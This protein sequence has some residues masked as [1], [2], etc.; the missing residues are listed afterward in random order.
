VAILVMGTGR[1]ARRVRVRV[2]VAMMK[3][4]LVDAVDGGCWFNSKYHGDAGMLERFRAL[5]G[6]VNRGRIFFF[7]VLDYCS[8]ISCLDIIG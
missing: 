5:D 1:A 3:E 4:G 2:A 6:E 7:T 8:V